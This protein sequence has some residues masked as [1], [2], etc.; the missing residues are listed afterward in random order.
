MGAERHSNGL[1]AQAPQTARPPA[2]GGSEARCWFWWA[3]LDS[4]QEPMDLETWREIARRPIVGSLKLKGA[5]WR[6]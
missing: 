1:S 6:S 4:N 5:R 3:I 2:C